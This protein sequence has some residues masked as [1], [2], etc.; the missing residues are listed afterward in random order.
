MNRRI[1]RERGYGF[2]IR[3]FNRSFPVENYTNIKTFFDVLLSH[4]IHLFVLF[5]LNWNALCMRLAV[6]RHPV[7][8]IL[9]TYIVIHPWPL[10]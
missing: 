3:E 4:V 9:K 10:V 1:E 7:N 2:G 8:T 5:I 6:A